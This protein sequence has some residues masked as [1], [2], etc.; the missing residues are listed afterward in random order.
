[1]MRKRTGILFAGSGL[2]LAGCAGPVVLGINL[3]TASTVGSVISTAATG[4]GLGEH[5]LSA[6][7]D[8]DCAI[9]EGALRSDRK[10]CE[11]KGSEA[12]KSDFKGLAVLFD[13]EPQPASATMLAQA[14]AE[15]GDIVEAEAQALTAEARE[16][17]AVALEP[18]ATTT[19]ETAPLPAMAAAAPPAAAARPA[20]RSQLAAAPPPAPRT[21]PAADGPYLV[22]VGAF[23]K[24]AAAANLVKQLRE[25]GYSAGHAS[26]KG[27]LT[28]VQVK[29]FGDANA[30]QAAASRIGR[31]WRIEPTVLNTRA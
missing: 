14:P 6:A 19:L 29:G 10:F 21:K 16:V 9:I 23:A 4:K 20:T 1:M 17:E 13:G 27:G 8:K 15:T 28:V 2:L 31:T 3:G 11:E 5:A 26:R 22:Q 18:A 30:A 12:T 25:A 7:T 24:P